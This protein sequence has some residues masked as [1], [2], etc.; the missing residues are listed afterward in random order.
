MIETGLPASPARGSGSRPV[1]VCQLVHG[2]EVGGV[3]IMVL[4]LVERLDPHQYH[5]T[6]ACLDL[7]GTLS[8]RAREKGIEV[9]LVPRRPGI[10]W[11]Y[12]ARLAKFLK[13]RRV[14][15]LHL[16]NPTP[17]FYGALAGRLARIPC[18]VYTEHGRDLSRGWKVRLAHRI[19]ARFV[20]R[21]VVVA[22]HGRR[23][24]MEG[25]GVD[26]RKI[27]RIYNGIDGR[28]FDHVQ[29]GNSPGRLAAILGT[30]GLVVGIVARLDPIKN[31][32]ALFEA[33]RML[34]P[35]L[36]EITLLVVGDG[37]ARA[38]LEA[39][40]GRLGITSKVRFLGARSDVPQLL[41]AMD[42]FVLPSHSEGLSLTLI[43]A[44]A[45]GKPIVATD[46]GGNGE[47]VQ[48]GY[49]GLLVAPDNPKA[50]ADAMYR[51]LSAPQRAREMGT[52]GRA[53]FARDF[54]LD[55]MVGGYLRLYESVLAKQ[56]RH[57]QRDNSATV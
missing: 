7:L 29:G 10:D 6:I 27:T 22:E 47:V 42:L 55:A 12:P 20:D 15:V 31:H 39:A 41:H 14:D 35:R 9:E 49:N 4:N 50:L 23:L 45:S 33:F 51:V 1:H 52:N 53:K 43:E 56:S 13:E 19:L 34:I 57:L 18:V 17:F 2:L 16:H 24:L 36:P 40:A 46:V 37:A 11:S 44:C 21:I 8:G 26:G 5:V 25:E 48:D 28:Q 3:E 38:E 54:T 30:A 32:R